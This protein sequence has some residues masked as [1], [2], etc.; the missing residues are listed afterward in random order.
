MF[1]VPIIVT[2]SS[3]ESLAIDHA[4]N[5]LLTRTKMVVTCPELEVITWAPLPHVTG[6]ESYEPA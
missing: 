1:V 3:G 6:V 4:K 2:P 5:V